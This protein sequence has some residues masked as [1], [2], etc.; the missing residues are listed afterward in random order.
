MFQLLDSLIWFKLNYK[1]HVFINMKSSKECTGI[2]QFTLLM[3][4]HKKT[5]ESKNRVNRGYLGNIH[6]LRNHKG[7][8]GSENGNFWL[9]SV[10]KVDLTEINNS[11]VWQYWLWSFKSGETKL[12]VFLPNKLK[13]VIE[14]WEL[15]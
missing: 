7:G 15:V 12:E 11:L 8:R 14:F 2:P 6:V 10:L 4:G 3:W 5:R 9:L 1:I 13:K